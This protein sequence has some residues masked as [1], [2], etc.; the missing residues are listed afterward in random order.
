MDKKR[1]G[2]T[3]TKTKIYFITLELKFI[4]KTKIFMYFPQTR[5][6]LNDTKNDELYA[7]DYCPITPLTSKTR[8]NKNKNQLNNTG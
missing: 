1:K 3:K 5:V 4:F 2:K 6:R 7:F 8:T